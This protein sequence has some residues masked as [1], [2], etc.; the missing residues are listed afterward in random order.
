MAV[1]TRIDG[2]GQSSHRL[3]HQSHLNHHSHHQLSRLQ[4][5]LCHL[6][7][8]TIQ[9]ETICI[10]VFRFGKKIRLKNQ[11][12]TCRFRSSMASLC[13]TMRRQIL[14]RA[15]YGWLAYCRHL[16]TVRTHLIS[17]VYPVSIEFNEQFN[18]NLSLTVQSWTELFLDKQTS[19]LPVNKNEIYRRIYSGGCDPSI[20]KQVK[21]RDFLSWFKIKL[22][23]SLGLAVSFSTLFIRIDWWR[24]KRDQ[25]N[26]NRTIPGISQRM[27]KCRR[28]R[29]KTRSTTFESSKKWTNRNGNESNDERIDFI[30]ISKRSR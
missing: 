17:L 27:A 20:R 21:K 2:N 4:A 11:L 7:L 18:R 24:A 5:R 15:F 30:I 29:Q 3:Q 19:K 25:S 28:N 23:S 16:K 9:Q 1:R 13:D 12:N 22:I 26:S 6:H 8:L 10:K 14:S